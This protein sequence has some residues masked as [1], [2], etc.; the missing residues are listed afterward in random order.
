MHPLLAPGTH[1]LRR[2]PEDAQLGVETDE[3]VVV[4]GPP[5]TP[6]G[7]ARRPEVLTA[8]LGAGLACADDAT[9]RAALPA[10]TDGKPWLRHTLAA[11]GRRVGDELAEAL[12]GRGSHEVRIT[13]FGHPA[14]RPLADDLTDLCSR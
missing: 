1:V 9:L 6:A 13:S 14:G 11:L 10:D 4:P 5:P 7:L 2:G 8:L 12:V 3:A